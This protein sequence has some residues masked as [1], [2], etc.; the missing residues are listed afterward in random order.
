MAIGTGTA[1]LASA[2][3]GA[4]G[5]AMAAKK[6][7]GGG[8]GG[9]QTTRPYMPAWL[10]DDYGEFVADGKDLAKKPFTPAF[11]SRYQASDAYGGLFNNPE[12]G[13]IQQQTDLMNYNKVSKPQDYGDLVKKVS[14][15]PVKNQEMY[16]NVPEYKAAWDSVAAGHDE[17]FGKSYNYDS[18][19][20]WV[21]KKI[22]ELMEAKGK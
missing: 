1:L 22:R 11:S 6:A 15:V 17:Q 5:S 9:T 10:E 3:I 14:G 4:A 16:D 12:L 21:E 19:A 20:N 2:A 7:K 13:E 18:D 8:G